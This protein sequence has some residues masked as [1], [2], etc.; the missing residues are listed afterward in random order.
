MKNNSSDPY[1]IYYANFKAYVLKFIICFFHK[2][3]CVYI[4]MVNNY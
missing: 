4:K 1:N 3:F 2:C